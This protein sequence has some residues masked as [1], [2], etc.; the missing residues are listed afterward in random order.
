MTGPTKRCSRCRVA[1]PAD[2]FSVD[3]TKADG[4]QGY[5]KECNAAY[6][7][8]RMAN[9]SDEPD[10]IETR[11]DTLPRGAADTATRIASA[12]QGKRADEA[13]TVRENAARI[14]AEAKALTDHADALILTASRMLTYANALDQLN[15]ADAAVGEVAA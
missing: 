4:L 7:R 13:K 9:A 12:R 1:K 2:A 5:C 6:Y 14:E 11:M 10:D 3:R 8:E 15:E